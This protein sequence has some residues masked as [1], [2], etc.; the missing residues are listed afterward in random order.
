MINYSI[1]IT[2]HIFEDDHLVDSRYLFNDSPNCG[3]IGEDIIM[4]LRKINGNTYSIPNVTSNFSIR[5][6][7]NWIDHLLFNDE[8]STSHTN[9][10]RF[11]QDYHIVKKYICFNGLR[12]CIQDLDKPV[13]YYVRYMGDSIDSPLEIQLLVSGNAGN[14]SIDNGIRYYMNSK[15][16]GHHNEPHVHVDIRHELSGSFSLITGKQL[17]KNNKIKPKDAN[18]I[19]LMIMEN[20]KEWIDYWNKHTDGLNVDLNQAFG[21]IQY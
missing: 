5:E 7:W 19:K 18:A 2:V 10:L 12:Y 11:V 8:K 1:H 15:E 6:L 14:L 20:Q 4:P 13:Q 21:L 3:I 9:V 17:Q 16:S